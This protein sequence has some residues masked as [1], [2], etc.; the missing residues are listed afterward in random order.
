MNTGWALFALACLGTIASGV[1]EQFG[2]PQIGG[3]LAV[4]SGVNLL[5]AAAWAVT[6][7]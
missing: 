7:G 6:Y 4:V 3:A 5:A 2:L 1:A